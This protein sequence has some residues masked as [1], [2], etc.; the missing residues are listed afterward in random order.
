MCWRTSAA[1]ARRLPPPSRGLRE[2]QGTLTVEWGEPLSK[3]PD[4]GFYCDPQT[5]TVNLD[6][7]WTLIIGIEHARSLML[8]ET[9]NGLGTIFFTDAM[10]AIRS[11]MMAIK[12]LPERTEEQHT[13]MI[14]LAAQWLARFDVSAQAESN[15]A[16]RFTADRAEISAQHYAASLNYAEAI[17][18]AI[19]GRSA[20]ARRAAGQAALCACARPFQDEQPAARHALFLLQE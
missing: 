1:F 9:A 14:R 13:R 7:A 8:R 17:A 10:Q 18:G 3:Y 5:N 4:I 6:M 2:R 20:A 19:D 15:F 16:N 12:T 11:E